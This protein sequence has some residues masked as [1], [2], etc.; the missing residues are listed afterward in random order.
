MGFCGHVL[1]QKIWNEIDM[2]AA[3]MEGL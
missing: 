2:K 1:A 3:F